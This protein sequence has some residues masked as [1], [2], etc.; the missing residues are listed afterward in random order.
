MKKVCA[1]LTFKVTYLCILLSASCSDGD[2]KLVN[3][4]GETNRNQGRLQYC[5][6]NR[7]TAVRGYGWGVQDT[8]VACGQLNH[9]YPGSY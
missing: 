5:D 2:I 7:W 4:E 8:K 6:S 3:D 9:T 1:K